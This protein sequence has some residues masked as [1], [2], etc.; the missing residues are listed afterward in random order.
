V[1]YTYLPVE[2]EEEIPRSE[3]EEQSTQ[4]LALSTKVPGLVLSTRGA[5]VS[6]LVPGLS[7]RGEAVSTLVPVLSR[8]A[9]GEVSKR[10]LVLSKLVLV[11]S[12]L[13]QVPSRLWWVLSKRE[14]E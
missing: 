7:T 8:Q 9:A 14:Q 11:L 10:V 3:Q 6:K 4:V 1:L 2:V 5:E 12:K 13:E